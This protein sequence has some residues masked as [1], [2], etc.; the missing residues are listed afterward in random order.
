MNYTK[1]VIQLHTIYLEENMKISKS[2][3]KV[4]SN[5]KIKKDDSF[6][7]IKDYYQRTYDLLK[8]D[9]RKEAIELMYVDMPINLYD[10]SLDILYN[11]NKKKY[12][13][14]LHNLIEKVDVILN[15][16]EEKEEE[17]QSDLFKQQF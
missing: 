2:P 10:M 9:K 1:W 3:K 8:Q 6:D 7:K 14:S 16:T 12:S 13:Q 4:K 17:L 15:Y 5:R 11:R